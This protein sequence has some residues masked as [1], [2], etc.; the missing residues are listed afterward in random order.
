MMFEALLRVFPLMLSIFPF[1][2]WVSF[3][4]FRYHLVKNDISEVK[5]KVFLASLPYPFQQLYAINLQRF[6]VQISGANKE[7]SA[8]RLQTRRLI[9][10]VP[11]IIASFV[12]IITNLHRVAEGNVFDF[13][14]GCIMFGVWSLSWSFGTGLQTET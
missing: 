10:S 7:K 14:L 2:L 1:Y 13:I 11:V 6:F 8:K 9:T 12:V 3:E 4:S 5:A